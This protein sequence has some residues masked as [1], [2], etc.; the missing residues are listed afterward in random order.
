LSVAAKYDPY[1]GAP[2]HS[3]VQG[4]EKKQ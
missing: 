3:F 4:T 1:T 2:Y